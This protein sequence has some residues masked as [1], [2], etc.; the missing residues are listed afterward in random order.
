MAQQY[1]IDKLKEVSEYFDSNNN[2]IFNNYSGLDVASITDLRNELRKINSKLVVIKN[3]YI[4]RILKNK[5]IEADTAG[6]LAGP[7]AVAFAERD[8]SEVL[9]I[10]FKYAKTS[11]LDVKG[12]LIDEQY[13][14]Q[15]QLVSLSK[16]PGRNELIAQLMA[17][18]NAPLQNFVYSCNDVIGRV[19][20]VLNA[21]AES[22]K[23][24][25]A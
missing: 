9:K 18:M 2:Y 23:E 14:G 15:E 3:N 1:K 4:K 13:F 24:G 17:T 22:K 8:V 12:G 19:V 16:L 21:V 11:S 5:N 7:T 10:L 20:R 25:A 6:S